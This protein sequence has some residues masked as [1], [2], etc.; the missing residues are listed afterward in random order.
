MAW[1]MIMLRQLR[2]VLIKLILGR[3]FYYNYDFIREESRKSVVRCHE[4]Y[5]NKLVISSN[6]SSFFKPKIHVIHVI[7]TDNVGDINCGPE[8]YLKKIGVDTEI[9]IHDL[10]SINQKKIRREDI[11]IIGGGG[12]IDYSDEWN[13]IINRCINLSDNVVIWGAGY[14]KHYLNKSVTDKIKL[15]NIKLVGIRDYI[16]KNTYVPCVSCMLPYFDLNYTIKRR[17]GLAKH[18]DFS[19]SIP[20][21]LL[22]YDYITNTDSL[23]SVIKFIGESEYIITNTYHMYYWATLLKKKVI[24]FGAFSS[25]FDNLRYPPIRYSGILEEDLKKAVVYEEA[26]EES[27]ERN[28]EFFM[29]IK[30]NYGVANQ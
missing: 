4:E 27:R 7:I 29:R 14:N 15:E 28:R 18:K 13:G 23:E 21:E 6:I 26:L 5:I 25:K 24:L 30:E 3:Q 16:D 1:G 12:L 11:V 19:E 17:I 9:I 10:E 2:K 22:Q 8:Y 20:E